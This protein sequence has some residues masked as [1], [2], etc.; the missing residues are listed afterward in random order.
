M[1]TCIC[2]RYNMLQSRNVFFYCL[3]GHYEKYLF[4]LK[5]TRYVQQISLQ[6]MQLLI[7]SKRGFPKRCRNKKYS[8]KN[9]ILIFGGIIFKYLLKWSKTRIT[10]CQN[11]KL[12]KTESMSFVPEILYGVLGTL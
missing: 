1:K 11:F 8:L 10:F 9:P 3:Q 5:N 4:N 2:P 6:W 7:C 12:V